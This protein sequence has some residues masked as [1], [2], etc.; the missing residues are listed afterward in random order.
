MQ[1]SPHLQQAQSIIAIE[2]FCAKETIWTAFVRFA[3]DRIPFDTISRS[4]ILLDP[5][6]KILA[7]K[8]MNPVIC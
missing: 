8:E 7:V 4:S 6:V 2:F 3:G 1:Y 5:V